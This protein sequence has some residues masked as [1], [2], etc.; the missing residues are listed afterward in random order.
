MDSTWN[1]N[2]AVT[3]VTESCLNATPSC[4]GQWS[5]VT[6]M[7]SSNGNVFRVTGHLCGNSPVTGEFPAQRPVTRSFDVFWDLRLNKRLSKQWCGWWFETPSLPLW[8]HCNG[9]GCCVMATLCDTS[10]DNVSIWWRQNWRHDNARFSA[11][12]SPPNALLIVDWGVKMIY[13]SPHAYLY[14]NV[15]YYHNIFYHKYDIRGP[16]QNFT[17]PVR[18][19][20][21]GTRVLFAPIHL[22]FVQHIC[23]RN[24]K[25][26]V[27]LLFL[28]RDMKHIHQY[29]T[30]LAPNRYT[31]QTV[32][33]ILLYTL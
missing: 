11:Y 28:L 21:Q 25:H 1:T 23:Q 12:C 27:E 3:S 8:R 29:I 10:D 30:S 5:L 32:R 9:T 16:E 6:M 19:G 14:T 18:K 24:E 13:H 33:I 20:K 2:F 31:K 7:T 17:W 15:S 26:N 4:T 22:L